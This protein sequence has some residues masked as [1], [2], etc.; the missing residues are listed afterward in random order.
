MEKPY[1]L[2]IYDVCTFQ[3][4]AFKT[5]EYEWKMRVS[6]MTDYQ[7]YLRDNGRVPWNDIT[8][9]IL[10][11]D[12]T[13]REPLRIKEDLLALACELDKPFVLPGP[14]EA[15][16]LLQGIRRTDPFRVDFEW[17]WFPDDN[18][19]VYVSGREGTCRRVTSFPLAF[20]GHTLTYWHAAKPGPILALGITAPWRGEMYIDNVR[21]NGLRFRDD[22]WG[23]C[24]LPTEL[25]VTVCA[26][27]E[28][29]PVVD[30]ARFTRLGLPGGKESRFE[31]IRAVVGKREDPGDGERDPRLLGGPDVHANPTIDL[32]SQQ[33]QKNPCE[34]S[35]KRICRAR[36]IE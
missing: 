30:G 11:W 17:L 23:V 28:W 32:S 19:Q 24:D 36:P 13:M 25:P 1:P 33:F 15:P 16:V 34:K 26:P 7:R 14:H 10:E 22:M 8:R 9:D 20:V 35:S 31:W 4:R 3:Q 21:V 12:K 5:P 18:D 27:P 29:R 6:L 2:P